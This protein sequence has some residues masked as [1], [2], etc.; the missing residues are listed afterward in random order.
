ML[1]ERIRLPDVQ[2]FADSRAISIDSVGIK[3]I[4]FPISVRTFDGQAQPS[5]AQF[6]MY[7]RLHAGNRCLGGVLISWEDRAGR[8]AAD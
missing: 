7:V 1:D 5:V 6:D 8:S 4:K 3:G 2:A